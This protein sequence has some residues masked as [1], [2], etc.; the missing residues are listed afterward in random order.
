MKQ[1]THLNGGEP[2]AYREIPKGAVL[3]LISREKR[4]RTNT[5]YI[6]L[7]EN[8]KFYHTNS[9]KYEKWLSEIFESV[10]EKG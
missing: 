10:E 3:L 5:E 7:Y 2:F 1:V 9:T 8:Q 6:F 4:D